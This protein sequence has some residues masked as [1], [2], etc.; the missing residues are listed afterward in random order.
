ME[1]FHIRSERTR[2]LRYEMVLRVAVHRKQRRFVK[3]VDSV[4]KV[5][6]V[7]R[8]DF[9]KR[10]DSVKRVDFV[11]RADLVKRVDSVKRV[12]FVKRVDLVKRVDFVKRVEASNSKPRYPVPSFELCQVWLRLERDPPS[13]RL[14]ISWFSHTARVS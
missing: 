10:V 1:L 13:P 6:F 3:R 12:D 11:K 8:A 9:V 7:K 14:E 2:Y 4:K 5:D